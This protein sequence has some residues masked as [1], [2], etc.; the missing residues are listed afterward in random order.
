MSQ[1]KPNKIRFGIRLKLFLPFLL[2]LVLVISVIQ[3]IWAP[4]ELT[5]GKEQFINSQ[6]NI[7]KTLS[8]SL[9]QNM[10]S[11]DLSSLHALLENSLLIHKDEWRA[12]VLFDN[13]G[14]QLYPI[15]FYEIN[16]NANLIHIEVELVE[17]G[18]LFGE[19]EL[20]TDWT[21]QKAQLVGRTEN[22]AWWSVILFFVIAGLMVL[23]QTLWIH[24][25]LQKLKQVTYEISQGNYYADMDIHSRDEIGDLAGSID[26]MRNKI[27]RTLDDL[28]EKESLQR[29][30]LETAPDAIITM[31]TLG[32]VRS[33]NPGAEKIFGY[34][35]EEVIGNN[36]KMLMPASF[37]IRHD[38]Q[39][40]A[41]RDTGQ[42]K[43]VNKY[44]ELFGK[45]KDGTEFPVEL[46]INS[47]DHGDD[48][49]FTGVIRDITERKRLDKI[50]DEFISTV[51]H[52]LRTPLTAIKGSLGLINAGINNDS[53]DVDKLLDVSMRNVER[54]NFLIDDILDISK[55]ESGN[56]E[57]D[58]QIIEIHKFL[59]MAIEVNADFA[60]RHKTSY[61]Y[62]PLDKSVAVYADEKRLL[63][64]ISNLMSNAA[65][66]SPEGTQVEISAEVYADKTVR[67]AVKD[68]GPGI[69]D[70]FHE[71][72]FD[73][74]TQANMGDTRQV[75]GTGLGLNIALSIVEQMQG[76]IE[77]ETE[78]GVGTTFFI[79][80]PVTQ[81][82]LRMDTEQ[83]AG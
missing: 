4:N 46:T 1:I 2:A 41:F 52:E 31:D 29:S 73:R 59:E 69:P 14:N 56:L 39:I 25:P 5:K 40:R 22:I 30:I 23:F 47:N 44:R 12:L 74:F 34:H 11:N 19:L 21:L 37:A 9:I 15:S 53:I 24:R 28:V 38:E 13:D 82:D 36:I 63:Q 48:I 6:T 72:L 77:F 7:L 42:T 65:K 55:L 20:Y 33:F 45:Q 16:S 50:K 58:Y 43:V 64:A 66:F 8:P 10:L 67:I 71:K 32:I 51:S 79:S 75:G 76:R 18:E 83:L 3:F 26:Y 70:E 49:L 81:A 54:L 62:V 60:A 78:K 27:L 57:F 61:H 35:P 68:H 17:E 80:L